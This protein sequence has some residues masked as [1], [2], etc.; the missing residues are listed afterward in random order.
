MNKYV[1]TTLIFTGIWLTASLLNGVL[2]GVSI[3]ILDHDWD[4]G[5]PAPLGL[6]IIFSFV[7]SVP[8]VGLV[9][10]ITLMAQVADRKGDDLLQFV[11]RTAL[12]CSTAGGLFFIYSLG[13]EF[14]NAR[15]LV[16]LSIIISALTSV[17]F[18]R[19]QI[20]TNE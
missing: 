14:K 15:F 11:L 2:S 5:S 16:A 7:F 1:K 6:S 10:F 8:L 19:K 3:L 12:L 13:T 9:W 18:F 4:Y 17:L 20:K